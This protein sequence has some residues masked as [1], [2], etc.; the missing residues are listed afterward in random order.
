M[1]AERQRLINQA[2]RILGEINQYFI[3]VAYWNNNTRVRLYPDAAPI[4]PDPTGEMAQ[5]KRG[6]EAELQH[7][8][9]LG[10]FPNQ[11]AP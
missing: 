4:D 7:E 1:N 3:D 2:A 5:W 11:V 8:A 10:N 9:K 6:L